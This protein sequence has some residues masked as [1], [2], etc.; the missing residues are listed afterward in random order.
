MTE[1][2]EE[3][4]VTVNGIRLTYRD[5]GNPQGTPLIF[6][7]GLFDSALDWAGIVPAFAEQYHI[8]ALNQRGHATSEYPGVYSF[9]LMAADIIGFLD[10]LDLKRAI[11]VGHSLGGIVSFFAA[12]QHPE[13]FAALVMEEAP[14]PRPTGETFN[15]GGRPDGKLPYDWAVVTAIVGELNHPDPTWWDG[16]GR[17]TAPVLMIGGG[18]TSHVPQEWISDLA[19][20]IPDCRVVTLGGGHLVHRQRPKPYIDAVK[21][22]LEG[23]N[24]P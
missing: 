6:V 19:A 20:R 12:G 4:A 15:F 21:A 18:P 2:G 23:L 7:H 17:I 11:V 1:F 9:A 13:R 5:Y 22:F 14:P 3:R 24:T 10:A 8:Y 16:A